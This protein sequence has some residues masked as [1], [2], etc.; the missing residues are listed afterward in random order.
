[1]FALR[2]GAVTGHRELWRDD[3]HD[4]VDGGVPP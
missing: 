2:A 4:L 1:M 3:K